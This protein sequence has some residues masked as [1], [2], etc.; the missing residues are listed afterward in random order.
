MKAEIPPELLPQLKCLSTHPRPAPG[1]SLRR[2]ASAGQTHLEDAALKASVRPLC[3]AVLV[4]VVVGLG[5][6]GCSGRGE[7]GGDGGGGGA[8][9]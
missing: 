8:G 7:G 5:R 2:Q 9:F 1:S 4:Q 6:G 3:S